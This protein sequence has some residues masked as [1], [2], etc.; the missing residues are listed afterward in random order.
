MEC[1]DVIN[2][3]FTLYS[4]NNLCTRLIKSKHVQN[5]RYAH[6]IL[7]TGVY[8]Y[9][10][11]DEFSIQSE[12]A[13]RHPLGQGCFDATC[14][15]FEMLVISLTGRVYSILGEIIIISSLT[16]TYAQDHTSSYSLYVV[17]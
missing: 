6:V 1:E 12:I 7:P 14:H 13:Q 3:R 8:G 9:N 11:I 17:C 2:R 4:V 15:R 10:Y 16:V 5:R